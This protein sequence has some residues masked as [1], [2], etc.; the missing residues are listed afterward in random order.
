MTLYLKRESFAGNTCFTVYNEQGYEIFRVDST[1]GKV[2]AKYE[3]ISKETKLCAARIR[4]LPS[5][6]AFT[7]VLRAGK[8]YLT[9]VLM[10]SPS[11]YLPKIYGKNWYINGGFTQK[12]FS[13]IDVDNSV[14]MS[15]TNKGAES[16]IYISDEVNALY[17]VMLSVCSNLINTVENTAV[18]AV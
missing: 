5:P 13:V 18:A 15:Q 6:A 14:V 10:P 3:V 9:L 11:S 2:A 7:Y 1:N 8:S 4:R 17:C 12:N 16:Q